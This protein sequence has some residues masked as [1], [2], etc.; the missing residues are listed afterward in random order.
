M[1]KLT[2]FLFAY[3]VFSAY[4]TIPVYQSSN[5]TSVYEMLNQAPDAKEYILGEL[6]HKKSF[7]LAKDIMM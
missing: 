1:R 3:V 7:L 5:Q 2:V 4:R 6:E